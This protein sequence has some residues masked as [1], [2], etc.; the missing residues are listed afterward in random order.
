MEY[1]VEK[2]FDVDRILGEVE[3]ALE[4]YESEKIDFEV[5]ESISINVISGLTDIL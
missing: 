4:K 1:I 3:K 5:L 2:S